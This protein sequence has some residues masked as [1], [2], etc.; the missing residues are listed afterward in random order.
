[1]TVQVS[2]APAMMERAVHTCTAPSANARAGS[3]SM[4]QPLAEDELA[5]SAEVMLLTRRPPST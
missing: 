5:L 2:H 3:T 1:M 4:V